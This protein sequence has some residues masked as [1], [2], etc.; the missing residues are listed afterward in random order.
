MSSEKT[1]GT[2]RDQAAYGGEGWSPRTRALRQ[3][4]GTVWGACGLS[5]EWGRLRAVL[6]HRPGEE[7][8]GLSD[9]NR[10][11]MIELP[12]V[13]RAREQH[14]GMARAYQDVGVAVHYVEPGDISLPNM[15][16]VAD[17]FFMTPEGAILGRAAST[18]RAGEERHIAC[19]LSALGIP[20]LRTVRG[21]G[22]FEGADAMWVDDRT[23]LL[24]TGLRTNEEGA[25]QVSA[26]LKEMGVEV[27]RVRL[28]HGTM[29]LMGVL[30]FVDRD[31][32]IVWPGLVPHAAVEALRRRGFEVLFIP[33]VQEA[34]SGMALNFVT[35]APREILMPT[36]N[37]VN[38]AFYEQAGIACRTV[39]VDELH[40]C[41]GGVACMTGILERDQTC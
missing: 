41:A 37:P 39:A 22:V 25:E 27:I 23:V 3:E 7:L 9:P 35:L 13:I 30:R 4:I 15:M 32:A 10:A 2:G 40:K 14:D 16:Y 33:D 1:R 17:M 12:D 24:A 36:G 29:H 31:M 26:L 20:I 8:E 11:L 34:V 6:L 18:V 19:R 5:T 38:Q 28:P 21:G